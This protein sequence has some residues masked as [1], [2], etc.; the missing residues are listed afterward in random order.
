MAYPISSKYND[1]AHCA[2]LIHDNLCCL[3]RPLGAIKVHRRVCHLF[4]GLGKED[5]VA[6]KA[7]WHLGKE[8]VRIF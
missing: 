5:V 4:E 6:M 8:A 2:M 1:F 3:F 7:S